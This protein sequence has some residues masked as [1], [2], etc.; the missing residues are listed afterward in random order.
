MAMRRPFMQLQVMGT[1]G[2]PVTMIGLALDMLGVLGIGP[3]RL[4]GV[5]IGTPH[6]TTAAVTTVV[7]GADGKPINSSIVNHLFVDRGWAGRLANDQVSAEPVL[8][9][10]QFRIGPHGPKC[11][12]SDFANFR[13]RHGNRC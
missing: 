4:F 6:A 13:A 2:C 7:I 12:E 11:F 3:I 9:P 10:R 5:P 1:L 8:T